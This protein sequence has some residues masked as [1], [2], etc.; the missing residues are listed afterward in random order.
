MQYQSAAR[1]NKGERREPGRW[2][3]W[4]AEARYLRAGKSQH[5]IRITLH[6]AGKWVTKLSR[7]ARP[8]SQGRERGGSITVLCLVRRQKSSM[9]SRKPSVSVDACNRMRSRASAPVHVI[10]Y[11]FASFSDCER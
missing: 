7:L 9:I 1:L 10:F 8:A 3:W 4:R 5:I 2:P 11:D 6:H